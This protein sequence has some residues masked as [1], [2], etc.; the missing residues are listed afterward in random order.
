LSPANHIATIIVGAR[1]AP[2][3]YGERID[4][5]RVLRTLEDAYGLP[6]AGGSATAEP[7]T[8]IWTS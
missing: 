5:Y 7:I 3:R 2:G 6:H 8:S 4:H 1:V